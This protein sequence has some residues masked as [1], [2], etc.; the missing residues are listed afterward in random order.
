MADMLEFFVSC[1]TGSRLQK[2]WYRVGE[3]ICTVS[4]AWLHV[5][6]EVTYVLK[7]VTSMYVCICVFVAYGSEKL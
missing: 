3:I 7:Y 2:R 4:Y 1:I 6:K 5:L